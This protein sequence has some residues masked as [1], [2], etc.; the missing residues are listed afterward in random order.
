MAYSYYLKSISEIRQKIIDNI[1]D[2]IPEADTKEGT[3]LSN[4]FINPIADEITALYGDMEIVKMNQSIITATG[5][6]LDLLAANY[7]VTRKQ[8]TQSTGKVRFYIANT[9]KPASQI[10]DDDVPEVIHIPIGTVLSTDGSFGNTFVSVQTT[11]TIYY[12][13]DNIKQLPIDGETGYRYL[14][15][16]AESVESGEAQNIA[17]GSI[18]TLNEYIY[19]INSVSNPFPFTGGVD[20]ENDAYLTYRVELAI[21]GNN[22]GTKDGYL[23]Y[24]LD[25]DNVIAGKVVGAGDE[26]MFRDGGYIQEDGTYHW[27][28]GG[29][30]DIYVRGHQVLDSSYIF[31]VTSDY[32]KTTANLILP[33]Q[34]VYNIQSI[35]SSATGATLLNAEGFDVEQYSY[36]YEDTVIVDNIYCTDIQWDFA[37]TD[38]FPDL[39]YYSLPLGLTTAQIERLKLLL[40]TELLDAREYMTNMNYGIDWSTAST[41]NTSEGETLLLKKVYVNDNVYKLVAKNTTDLDGRVFIMKNDQIYVRAYV[42]PDFILVKDSSNYAGSTVGEDAIKWLS[43]TNLLNNDTLTITYNYD[44]LIHELQAGIEDNKCLTANVL[45]KQAIEVPIEIIA[46]ITVYNTTTV[47]SVKN[48]IATIIGNHIDTDSRLGGTIYA[49]TVV[50]WIQ[51][52]EY[53][54]RI[55]LQTISLSRKGEASVDEI[56]ISDNEYFTLA[57]LVLNVT[58]ED[59]IEA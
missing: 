25:Q 58:V 16:A 41:R 59:S 40:D 50:S 27:G 18:T 52:N 6:D 31:N 43:T 55:D 47:A 48:A 2:T 29:C 32:L 23:K 17:A 12:T 28:K 57:N 44:Y 53:V 14:E 3:F 49:N 30:V 35:T 13:R 34:P 45:I 38:T 26:I 51:E 7:F 22:I 56:T 33:N 4:V 37:L 54:K 5:D 24:V 20:E 46:D 42:E 19:G 36:T 39:E 11:E 21:T 9:N 8:A 10:E 1:H 15:C